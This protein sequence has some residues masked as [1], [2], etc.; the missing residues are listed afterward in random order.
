[1]ISAFAFALRPRKFEKKV[2]LFVAINPTI[3]FKYASEPLM[4]SAAKQDWL[5]DLIL[6]NDFLEINKEP[7]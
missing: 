4:I 3:E 5:M 7:N 1:M 6:E 2:S